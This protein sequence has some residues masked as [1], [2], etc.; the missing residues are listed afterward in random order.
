MVSTP[1]DDGKPPLRSHQAGIGNTG[2]KYIAGRR[3]P[4]LTA[5]LLFLIGGDAF[6]Q[7]LVSSIERID[8]TTPTVDA[9][10]YASY[11]IDLY[12]TSNSTAA[13][14]VLLTHEFGSNSLYDVAVS[15]EAVGSAVCPPATAIN[16]VDGNSGGRVQ[17]NIPNLPTGGGLNAGQP[18]LEFTVRGVVRGWPRG[19]ITHSVQATA[20][21]V[22]SEAAV[23]NDA[24]VTEQEGVASLVTKELADPIPAGGLPWNTE[25]RYLIVFTNNGDVPMPRPQFWDRHVNLRGGHPEEY[26]APSRI[27][28]SAEVTF[29]NIAGDPPPAGV[30]QTC[31]YTVGETRSS[32][33]EYIGPLANR[34]WNN[35]VL[36]P[37]QSIVVRVRDTLVP[38]V[39][40][41]R[42][43]GTVD[44]DGRITLY[45]Y[46]FFNRG[47]GINPSPGNPIYPGDSG[48]NTQTIALPMAPLPDCDDQLAELSFSLTKVPQTSGTGNLAWGTPVEWQVT[49]ENVSETDFE[50]V[51][52]RLVDRFRYHINEGPA[53]LTA[54][55]VACEATGGAVCPWGAG[56][57]PLTRTSFTATRGSN[58]WA[59]AA[60]QSQPI[61]DST[62][63]PSGGRLAITLSVTASEPS[64]SCTSVALQN[65][66]WQVSVD[67]PPAEPIT[68]AAGNTYVSWNIVGETGGDNNS[69]IIPGPSPTLR[70]GDSTT[71]R[72]PRTGSSCGTEIVDADVQVTQSVSLPPT[73]DGAVAYD[74]TVANVTGSPAVAGV[75]VTDHL[76]ESG[77][78]LDDP[79]RAQLEV[80]CVAASGGATCPNDTP[81]GG[82]IC[83]GAAGNTCALSAQQLSLSIDTL[84]RNASVTMRVNGSFGGQ[85]GGEY[86]NTVTVEPGPDASYVDTDPS[87]DVT[88]IN[89]GV[90]EPSELTITNNVAGEGYN[91]GDF[92][93]SLTCGDVEAATLTLGDGST[94]TITVP[95]QTECVLTETSTPPLDPGYAW[96]EPAYEPGDTFNL[97][98]NSVAAVTVTNTTQVA[99]VD[100]AK[101]AAAVS[102]VGPGVY[103]LVYTVTATNNN[104]SASVY[105]L[106]DNFEPDSDVALVDGYPTFEYDSEASTDG[107]DAT[108]GTY[109][110]PVVAGESIAG[111]GSTDV[112]TV[113]ARF[114]VADA[115][116]SDNDVCTGAAGHGLFNAVTA[117]VAGEETGTAQACADTPAS[118]ASLSIGKALSGEDGEIQ[119]TAEPGELLTYTITVQN[120]GGVKA[121][122]VLVADAVPAHTAFETASDGGELSGGD[123]QWTVDV[124]ANGSTGLTVAFRV[125]D[126]LPADVTRIDNSATVNGQVCATDPCVSTPTTEAELTISK[127]LTGEDG[128]IPETAEPGEL[129]TYTITVQNTTG[130]GAADVPVADRVPQSTT[131]ESASGG[132]ALTDGEVQWTVDVPANGSTDLTVSFRVVDPIPAG[133]QSID[134]VAMVDGEACATDPCVSTPTTEAEFTISKMLT[135]EDGKLANAA[136]P[137]EQ[138]TYTITVQNVSGVDAADVSVADTVPANTRHVNGGTLAGDQVEWTIDALPAGDS[139]ELSVT[140][141]VDDTIPAGAT[142]IENSATVNGAPCAAVP[143]V[144]T[145]IVT[146]ELTIGKALT[147]ESGQV[148]GS[149]EPGEQL[150][151]TLTVENVGSI[152]AA[153]VEVVDSLPAN[154]TFVS[155][156][157]DGTHDGGD[158]TWMI[159][160]EAGA[161]LPLEVTVQAPS[162]FPDGLS[163]IV[164]NATVNDQPCAETPCVETPAVTPPV[165]VDDE[166]SEHVPGTFAVVPV[167]DNDQA[168]SAPLDPASI[169]I[170]GAD[171]EGAGLTVTGEGVWSVDAETGAVTF[172]PEAGFTDDPTP[173][174]Y[175]VA[176]LLGLRSNEAEIAL[177][178]LQEALLRVS[179]TASARTVVVGDLLIYT[180]TIENIG[181]LDVTDVTVVDTP[182]HGFALV[183]DSVSVADAD[184][185]GALVS[186][187]PV[188]IGGIDVAIGETATMSFAMAVGAGVL[189]GPQTSTSLVVSGGPRDARV[190]AIPGA[191]GGAKPA[192][193]DGQSDKASAAVL[194]PGEVPI[195]NEASVTVLTGSDPLLEQVRILGTVFHDR[196]QDGWR[197][198]AEATGITVTGGI[199]ASAYVPDS[200]TIDRGNGPE[201][202]A[203][204]GAGVPLNHGI[205]LGRLPGRSTVAVPEDAQHIVI[206]QRLREPAFTDDFVLT[207]AQGMTVTMDAAGQTRVEKS[208][209]AAGGLTAQDIRVSRTITPVDG[210]YR[211]DYLISNAGVREQGL[212]GVRLGTVTGLLV[213]TDAYGRYHLEGIETSHYA[214]GSNIIVKVDM[215]TL[216][217]GSTLTTENPRIRRAT[218][219]LPVRFDFG[220]L[221]PEEVIEGG[222][223]VTEMTLGT[224][225]FQADS[226]EIRPEYAQVIAHMAEQLRAHAG[227]EVEIVGTGGRPD[228]AYA[229]A[230]AVQDALRTRLGG[231]AG[232]QVRI[233]ARGKVDGSEILSLADGIVIGEVFF[234]TDS[235]AIKPQFEALFE[236]IAADIASGDTPHLL[237]TGHADE[238]GPDAYNLELGKRRAEAVYRAIAANLP[239]ERSDRLRVEYLPPTAPP[240]STG[241]AGAET[242]N[243]Q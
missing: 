93:F 229:R 8:P 35:M 125:D 94:E 190:G 120:S 74:L 24:L 228:L 122:G 182:P 203:D 12:N 132:G 105:T 5:L 62:E 145:P 82:T 33:E 161:S 174:R 162:E 114:T 17:I 54:R 64:G 187:N 152:G 79:Y 237:I 7:T 118:A 89:V 91:G 188:R 18:R 14:D 98:P 138:L 11:R 143:C 39:C 139:A 45:N 135:G 63:I 100:V 210:A 115:G 211:A 172:T 95:S 38:P 61:R 121:V 96:G 133:L 175:T 77:I 163:S 20:G 167:S 88:T 170:V 36:Y 26:T 126:S 9:P 150:T 80:T 84:P 102:S 69:R 166:G 176:D 196:D 194:L 30:T 197:D 86:S 154:T 78:R 212:P 213:E 92:D 28:N 171:S 159:D 241:R 2:H 60:A 50:N 193:V 108:L 103:E 6:S 104:E 22:S 218:P 76:S 201:S 15:C 131:F 31:P 219:G 119:D 109:P 37:G 55:V 101:S 29:C 27:S 107:L 1:I 75:A 227:G 66:V 142:H 127:Q 99:S 42:G 25:L 46:A 180:I 117:I 124:P 40:M 151:Y 156:D 128:E 123:V 155:A 217:P 65:N 208:G 48:S 239:P 209:D 16:V 160:L 59:R 169:W 21:A 242:E 168:T 81:A 238:R 49:I 141:Q 140:F 43:E 153:D 52:V 47:R 148:P 224:V 110:N 240:P 234:D 199:D 70:A 216:P 215:A 195:S 230:R 112:Y 179:M 146:P 183:A 207:T 23:I 181:T 231:P 149:V 173:V 113:T 198:S 233:T 10:G 191:T 184:N 106:E 56:T 4:I 137:G 67:N 130:V 72:Y 185:A 220:V 83:T 204:A 41:N 235:A 164:N 85:V 200:T 34:R 202:R 19:T 226:A 147:G 165:A 221:M 225:V 192:G 58:Y 158:V 13:T 186:T 178:Y 144:S 205:E 189:P 32:D 87:N 97:A 236:A 223:E 134:N 136:E 206:S 44:A 73:V 222:V 111:G 214:R 51:P 232:E 3:L 57:L 177:D 243:Q 157:N 90:A 68:D 129:L 53:Q 71:V 116:S